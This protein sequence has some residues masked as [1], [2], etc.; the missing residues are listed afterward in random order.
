MVRGQPMDLDDRPMASPFSRYAR[1]AVRAFNTARRVANAY[2]SSRRL[3]GGGRAASAAPPNRA[4]RLSRKIKYSLSGQGGQ[5]K[6]M[7]TVSK[8]KIG[9]KPLKK[10]IKE[11][12][13]KIHDNFMT[14]EYKTNSTFQAASVINRCGYGVGNLFTNVDFENVLA[15]I[16]YTDPLF[17][18]TK[19]TVDTRI[20]TVATR[21]KISAYAECVMRNNYLYPLHLRCYII[22]P[23]SDTSILPTTSIA[24]IK[25]FQ[26]AGPLASNLIYSTTDPWLYPTDSKDFTDH[27]KIITSCDM[28]LQ[29]GDE[30]KVPYSEDMEYDQEY[31]DQQPN[32]FTKKWTR[33]ILVRVVGVVAHDLTDA[34]LVGIC[35]TKVDAIVH[36]KF[37][38]KKP[39][40]IPIDVKFVGTNLGNV[41][42]AVV[43]VSSAEVEN[44]L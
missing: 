21:W 20:V 41:S 25:P 29:S 8:K 44:A 23:K 13:E 16:P 30:C 27:W 43:G 26:E 35:P 15:A 2:Q 36:A 42:T 32:T 17:P 37:L 40:D 7:H 4:Q 31:L 3:F 14:Y 24:N 6:R 9:K 28:K 11:L 12:E 1:H 33:F 19:Q 5:T 39:A 38:L 22:K 34:A 18:G 10:R